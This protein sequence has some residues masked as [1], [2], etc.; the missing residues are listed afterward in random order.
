MTAGDKIA[1]S[2]EMDELHAFSNQAGCQKHEFLNI[3]FLAIHH[4][5][6]L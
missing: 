4:F 3:N 1:T 6:M 5:L 2:K